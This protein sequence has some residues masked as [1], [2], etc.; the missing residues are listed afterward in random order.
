MNNLF[1][2]LEFRIEKVNKNGVGNFQHN[3]GVHLVLF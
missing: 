3:A 2:F 1:W